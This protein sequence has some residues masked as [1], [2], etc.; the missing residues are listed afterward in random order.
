MYE[1]MMILGFFQKGVKL[2]Q[3]TVPENAVCIAG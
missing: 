3:V 2:F 1:V